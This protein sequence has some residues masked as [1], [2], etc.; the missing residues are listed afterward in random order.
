MRVRLRD[1]G[2][3]ASRGGLRVGLGRARH[4][5]TH[6]PRARDCPVSSLAQGCTSSDEMSRLPELRNAPIEYL[7]LLAITPR[8]V[9]ERRLASWVLG[10]SSV[11]GHKWSQQRVD[12][13]ASE[14]VA[15][16]GN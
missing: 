16:N 8:F 13:V 15:V 5:A 6:M 10:Q 11:R 12:T 7:R 2:N 3:A 1:S 14:V 4:P 9:T